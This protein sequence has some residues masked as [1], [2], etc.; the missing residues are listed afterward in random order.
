MKSEIAVELI[1]LF[2]PPAERTAA[3][4][5]LTVNQNRGW[6]GKRPGAGAPR[7]NKNRT[8]KIN[9]ENQDSHLAEKKPAE[10]TT[11]ELVVKNQDLSQVS[12]SAGFQGWTFPKPI[13]T[14]AKKHW[15]AATIRKIEVNFS[16]QEYE[17][18]TSVA[19]LLEEYPADSRDATLD[20][21]FTTFWDMFPK[22]RAGSKETAKKK[23][24]AIIKNKKATID[25]LLNGVRAY[26]ASDEVARG[27]AKGCAAWL[28]DDRWTVN[29]KPAQQTKN[30]AEATRLNEW[31]NQ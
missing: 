13:L 20:I 24:V 22:Q 21:A 6:G 23:F 15:G 31:M 1:D 11:T 27:F 17:T 14:E 9:Q 26:R 25:E 30:M 18:I 2:V 28:N 8:A 10:R 3:L 29:Y 5:W 19:K 7:G 4:R 16:C 12:F